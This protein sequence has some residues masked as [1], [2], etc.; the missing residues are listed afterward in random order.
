[1]NVKNKI[2]VKQYFTL[3]QTLKNKKNILGKK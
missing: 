1:M 2:Q 3:C